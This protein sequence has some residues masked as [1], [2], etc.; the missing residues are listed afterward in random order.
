MQIRSESESPIVLQRQ[1]GTSPN[2]FHTIIID[3]TG[4]AFPH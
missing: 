3:Q 2:Y 4:G 1:E